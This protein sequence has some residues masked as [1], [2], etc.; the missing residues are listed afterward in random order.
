R[1]IRSFDEEHARPVV[2]LGAAISES[3]FPNTHPIRKTVRING[4]AY[5]V[6]GVFE[7]DQGLFL[8]PGV[9]IFTIIPLSN[10]RKNYPE[11][12][13]L[14]LLFTVPQSVNVETAQGEV[15]QAMRRLRR[16]PTGKDNEFQLC[17]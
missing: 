14:I 9:D 8:G 13:E 3:L 11:A 5:E 17:W 15:L 6:I 1:F 16:I 10:F 12:K 2:V 7:H 4:G